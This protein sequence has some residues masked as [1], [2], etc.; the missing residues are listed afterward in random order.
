MGDWWNKPMEPAEPPAE[1]AASDH[2]AVCPWCSAPATGTAVCPSC[3]AIMAQRE[4]LGA[5]VIPGVTD[6]DSNLAP[7]DVPAG[8]IHGQAVQNRVALALGSPATAGVVMAGA[9]AVMA[10]DALSGTFQTGETGQN[11]G[12]PSDAAVAMLRQLESKPT[13][14]SR[15]GGSGHDTGDDLT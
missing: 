4:H 14:D 2:P 8:A 12:K 13:P 5:L 15:A 1:E 7:P 9:A 6:V 10:R 3:G 11:V